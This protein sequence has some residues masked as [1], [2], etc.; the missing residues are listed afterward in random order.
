MVGGR[1]S[2]FRAEWASIGA[3]PFVLQI[4]REGYSLP[5]LRPP[6]Q[7]LPRPSQFTVLSK[8]DQ[9]RVVDEEVDALLSKGAIRRVSKT[10]KGLVSRI[11][12]VPKKDGGWRP[13]INLK[14]LNKTFLDP[15]HFRMDTV[16]DAASLLRPGDWTASIDLKDAYFHVFVNRRFR[17]FLR[18]G[19]RGRLYEYLVLP[20]GLCLA[21]LIFT[22]VTKPLKAF[23]SARG[24][25]SVFYLDDILII[26]ASRSECMANLTI[27]L[28]LLSRVGFVVNHKKSSLVP[29]Q[30]FRF[31]GFD[32]D[33]VRGLTSIDDVKR[34]NLSSRALKMAR[35]GFPLC[36]DLQIVLG[37]LTS[38]IPAVPLIRL[39]SRFLQRDLNVI[40][41]SEADASRRVPLSAESRRDLRWIAS[42]DSPQ[43]AAPMWPLQMED[44]ETEVSTDASDLG[45]G[46]YFRGSLHRG[47]WTSR[48]DAPA[49][50]NVKELMT[51]LIFLQDFLPLSDPPLSLLWRTDSSTALSYIRKEGGTVSRPLLLLARQIL[52]LLHQRRIRIYPVFVSS[53]ENLLADAAS[54]FQTLPDWH[55][56]EATFRRIVRRWGLPAI[57]LFA[58]TE[59]THLP[60][61]FAWGEAPEAEALDALQQP[62]DFALAYAFPPPPILLRVLRKIAASSG[63]FLL[64]TPFWPAQKWFPAILSLRVV[65]VRRLPDSP[66]VL[67][68]ATGSPP[69]PRLPL[70]VWKISGGSEESASP[71]PRSGSSPIAGVR[72]PLRDMTPPGALSGNTS[73]PGEFLSFPS[74]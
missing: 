7:V 45:W 10:S 41:R 22:L 3:P 53:E 28:R 13:I 65:D 36:R 70:L 52:L 46:I 33:T 47:L 68:L 12:V 67:D 57:D 55:L 23:L 43:C 42:L 37:H 34:R 31:L 14:W 19:W 61:F 66:P 69:L 30:Q 38:A 27:A 58:S 2:N 24:I 56:P 50:I 11:F 64:V 8:P 20:F 49:H 74:I 60:R 26:G 4:L 5:F 40:Y 32:W 62:W 9:I 17:R 18:F 16:S 71:T 48:A 21:P 51:L 63:V 54:R 39:H 25:R 72:L 6:P 29:A 35:D 15:P 1:L 73:I 44:C 59:S